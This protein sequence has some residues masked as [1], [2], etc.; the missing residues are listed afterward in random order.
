MRD[1]DLQKCLSNFTALILAIFYSMA[2]I[3][4]YAWDKNKQ[5]LDKQLKGN[6][7]PGYTDT[8]SYIGKV[9]QKARQQWDSNGDNVADAG[10]GALSSSGGLGS[11][12]YWKGDIS[13]L[14][15]TEVAKDLL[16]YF[17]DMKTNFTADFNGCFDPQIDIDIGVFDIDVNLSL[18]WP[19]YQVHTHPIFQNRYGDVFQI[20]N[21]VASIFGVQLSPTVTGNIPQPYPILYATDAHTWTPYGSPI[22]PIPYSI[23]GNGTLAYG[24][25]RYFIQPMMMGHAKYAMQDKL[26]KMYNPLSN[27][28][29]YG[30]LVAAGMN[31]LPPNMVTP[32][33]QYVVPSLFKSMRYH[34]LNP[35]NAEFLNTATNDPA[36]QNLQLDQF[37][38]LSGGSLSDREYRY[39][40]TAV[41]GRHP[42]EFSVLPSLFVLTWRFIPI[43]NAMLYMLPSGCRPPVK[44]TYPWD[45]DRMEMYFQTRDPF[46]G[47]FTF[48]QDSAFQQDYDRWLTNAN[49]CTEFEMTN[50]AA[51]PNIPHD[52]FD[53]QNPIPF[54]PNINWPDILTPLSPAAANPLRRMC[55]AKTGAN[56]PF[57][58][59]NAPQGVEVLAAL[60][61]I[62]KGS[63]LS[64]AYFREFIQ[65]NP[66]YNALYT[67]RMINEAS[68]SGDK[69]QFTYHDDVPKECQWFGQMG[70]LFNSGSSVNAMVKKGDYGLYNATIWQRRSCDISFWQ[71]VPL[72]GM[73]LSL[74]GVILAV[75]L[76]G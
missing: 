7:T 15:P 57:T 29:A 36:L 72:L 35:Y 6:S 25:Q 58:I 9:S 65:T 63:R 2:P 73:L 16:N 32:D 49:A 50:S 18:W 60:Q 62:E 66:Q 45:S 3:Y 26:F 41:S 17:D 42:L 14:L 70:E 28:Q 52:Q 23:P 48:T 64:F 51:Y 47:K 68:G 53:V 11:R 8:N 54:L 39:A 21:T 38:P 61:N 67:F 74:T 10:S 75:T 22:Y 4:A 43:L 76:F 40:T 56:V 59:H 30:I 27:P 1:K 31:P 37:G 24:A 5:W 33:P 19:V 12:T 13:S 71:I 55:T 44:F 20:I 46:L 34:P 69:I